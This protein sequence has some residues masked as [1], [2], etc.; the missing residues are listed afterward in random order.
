M[1]Y[2]KVQKYIFPVLCMLDNFACFL[3]WAKK[4]QYY[5]ACTRL[6]NSLFIDLRR[7]NV[8]SKMQNYIRHLVMLDKLAV[9]HNCFTDGY[10]GLQF[11]RLLEGV[12]V[13]H[14]FLYKCR[15]N[16][17]TFSI[18][19]RSHTRLKCLYQNPIQS[20]HKH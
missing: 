19:I 11:V 5:S 20:K 16:E 10:F 2:H 14:Q 17:T 1:L 8:H 15:I 3:S 18:G 9:I 4:M 6:P 13:N 7:N 12:G